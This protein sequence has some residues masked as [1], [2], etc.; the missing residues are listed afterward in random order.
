MREDRAVGA[1]L[2]LACGDALGRPLVF[3]TPA[4]IRAQYGR[5]TEMLGDGTWG[6][7]AGTVTDDT[8]TALCVAR[9]LVDCGGF[10]AADVARRLVAW[11]ESGSRHVD[12][13]TAA[14]LSRIRDGETPDAA[15]RHV[16]EASPPGATPD[17]GCLPRA[18]P[19]AV[20]FADDG[21]RLDG[22]SRDCAAITHGDPR[23]PAACAVA[24]RTLAALL[25]D[26]DDPLG[27][28]L[29]RADPPAAVAEA[30][31]PVAAGAV[32]PDGLASTDDAVETLRTGLWH[33]LHADTAEA[34]LVDAVNAGGRADTLGAVTGAVAGA[35]F[36]A[37]A[38][39]ERWRESLVV[40]EAVG[41]LAA[42]LRRL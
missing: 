12:E 42:R 16:W 30:L 13:T 23:C 28:A 9:S 19:L 5:V 1:L 20:A 31:R 27:T 36:G 18:M 3:E 8:E 17:A 32:D 26:R 2:G 24:N 33:G 35:R 4:R 40:G 15:G 21:D 39:P 14:A 37:A 6:D 38:L 10:D 11:A 34:A 41:D 7:P 29:D 22:T 25:T